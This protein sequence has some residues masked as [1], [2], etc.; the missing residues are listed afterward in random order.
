MSYLID[1]INN[2]Y[3]RLPFNYLIIIYQCQ[4]SISDY[5]NRSPNK[6]AEIKSIL[7]T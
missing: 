7:F 2:I 1:L 4:R 3:V 6:I 5:S